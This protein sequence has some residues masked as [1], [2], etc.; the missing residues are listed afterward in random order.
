MDEEVVFVACFWED[1]A[2]GMV[3]LDGRGEIVGGLGGRGEGV[4][5]FGFGLAEVFDEIGCYG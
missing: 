1:L 5:V 3:F 2:R 4:G